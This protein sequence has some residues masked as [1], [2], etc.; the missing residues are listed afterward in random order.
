MVESLTALPSRG[1]GNRLEER[2]ILR[3]VTKSAGSG[4]VLE[5]RAVA[6]KSPVRESYR[7]PGGVPE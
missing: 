5:R 7:P 1:R 2:Q 6:G 4:I 3:G